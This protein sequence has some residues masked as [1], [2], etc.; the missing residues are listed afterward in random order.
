MGQ[1]LNSLGQAALIGTV[2]PY[3]RR[4][5]PGWGK[6]YRSLIGT[7]RDDG[8]WAGQPPRWVRG[9]FHDYEMR[10]DIGHWSN[11]A[12]Y[13]LGRF[14]DLPTQL[15]L[16]NV[17]RP[18]DTTV[19]IGGNEGM[20]SLLLSRLVGADGHVV[21]FEPNPGPRGIFEANLVRNQIANVTVHPC[22]LGDEPGVLPLFVPHMNSGEGSFGVPAYDGDQGTVVECSVRVGDEVLAGASP[23]VIKIDV[24]GFELHV[25]RGLR[26][27]IARSYPLIVMEMVA[28]HLVRAGASP[29]ALM[30]ELATTRYVGHRLETVRAGRRHD[31]RLQRIDPA[32]PW[33]DGDVLW[34]VP[35]SPAAARLAV[36]PGV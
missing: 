20:I 2:R 5:L 18:G 8:F 22:G 32:A 12:T 15:L 7:H 10:V 4:E 14:Y 30:A 19:D 33:I 34:S 28:A 23:A 27:T 21:A 3:I 9:K 6:L 26:A 16:M 36:Y 1:W 24:E 13:F 31:L 35:G 11:R 29:E 25:L 17:V